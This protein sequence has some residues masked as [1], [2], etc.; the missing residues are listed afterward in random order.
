[1]NITQTI[2]QSKEFVDLGLPS[3]TLWATCNIGAN[4]PED[5]GNYFAWSETEEKL[6]YDWSTY[7]D[8]VDG[9]NSNFTKYAIGKKTQ[10][11]P[12][13]DV[14]H[15]KLGCDWRMPTKIELDELCEKCEWTWTSK[16]GHNGYTVTGPNGN[17]IFLPAAGCR[18]GA[19]SI[20]VGVYGN[21]WSSTLTSSDYSNACNLSFNSSNHDMSH[22]HHNYGQSV[23]PV[24]IRDSRKI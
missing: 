4:K 18:H 23:R 12:E 5:Y 20:N 9:S 8:S 3:G 7:F 24:K 16:N 1:M 22:S 11:D 13:N 2:E 15:V 21:Y 19:S 10:L 17:S 14:A 6:N